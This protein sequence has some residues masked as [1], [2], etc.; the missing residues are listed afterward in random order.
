MNME[1]K[2]KEIYKSESVNVAVQIELPKTESNCSCIHRK[3][4]LA[5]TG[6]KCKTGIHVGV[7]A[8]NYDDIIEEMEKLLYQLAS[9]QTGA[10]AG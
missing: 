7:Y 10:A 3:L 5:G 8:E 4:D 9:K 6:I 1:L 2:F